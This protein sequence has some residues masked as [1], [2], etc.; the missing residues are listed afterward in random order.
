MQKSKYYIK[1]IAGG[2]KM[3]FIPARP[4]NMFESKIPTWMQF[5]KDIEHVGNIAI[6]YKGRVVAVRYY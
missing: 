5:F 2:H 3:N 4:Q 6:Y 1:D